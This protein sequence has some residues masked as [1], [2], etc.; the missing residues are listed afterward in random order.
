MGRRGEEDT[1]ADSALGMEPNMGLDLLTPEIMTCAII[2]SPKPNGLSHP[3]TS[4]FFK[5][6]LMRMTKSLFTKKPK[7][8]L[9][10]EIEVNCC[11]C[12]SDVLL[13]IG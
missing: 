6:F 9:S 1:L 8:H 3:G 11:I 5:T 10:I 4:L 7:C 2:K 12:L 13:K